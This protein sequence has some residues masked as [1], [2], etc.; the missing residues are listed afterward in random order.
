MKLCR[1]SGTVSSWLSPGN[2]A[3]VVTQAETLRETIESTRHLSPEDHGWKGIQSLSKVQK[4]P[5]TSAFALTA[6]FDCYSV[7]F[8][9]D[10]LLISVCKKDE[11]EFLS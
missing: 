2:D 6:F 3:S 9:Y 5:F 1:E 8:T 4:S 7:I 11:S 10:G